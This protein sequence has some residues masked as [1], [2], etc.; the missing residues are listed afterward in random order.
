MLNDETVGKNDVLGGAL[1]LLDLS[2]AL[3]TVK[4]EAEAVSVHSLTIEGLNCFIEEP[5]SRR[6]AGKIAVTIVEMAPAEASFLGIA[7]VLVDLLDLTG[8]RARGGDGLEDTGAEQLA[9]RG[10]PA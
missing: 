9:V 7:L 4:R 5:L 6:G 1:I 2:P 3:T 8:R 10:L